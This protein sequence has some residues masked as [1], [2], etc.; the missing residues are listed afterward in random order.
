MTEIV[1]VRHARTSWSGRRYCGRS[2]PALDAVGRRGAVE[3]A[4]ALAP[5]LARDVRIVSSPARRARQT[6][7]AL[8]AAAGIDHVEIDERWWEADCGVADGR[9]FD[10]LVTIEPELAVA[11]ARGDTAIDWP[12]GETAAEF[13]ARI[14]AAWTSLLER[15]QPAVVVSHAGALRHAIALARALPPDRVDFPDLGT[16]V[17][18]RVPGRARS[19]TVLPSPA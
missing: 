15:D 16:A 13:G 6:A 8:A 12:G 18:C 10:E 2:D 14:E 4:A 9:T 19:A 17:R 5:T 1:F 7:D 3:L 11:L